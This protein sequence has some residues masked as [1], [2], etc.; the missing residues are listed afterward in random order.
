MYYGNRKLWAARKRMRELIDASGWRRMDSYHPATNKISM[1]AKYHSPRV[2]T[3]ELE[4]SLKEF[5][6]GEAYWRTETDAMQLEHISWRCNKDNPNNKYP[7]DVVIA[8]EWVIEALLDGVRFEYEDDDDEEVTHVGYIKVIDWENIEKNTF[9]YVENWQGAMNDRFAWDFVLFVNGLPLGGIVLEPDAD[10]A[11]PCQT[12]YDLAM[13]Q[14][15]NDFQ[16]PVY[17]Q[18]LIVS[19]GKQFMVGNPF[20]VEE[21]RKIDSLEKSL[22][23]IDFLKN[24]VRL[25]YMDEEGED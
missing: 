23:P 5:N 20:V 7:I 2:N 10:D 14:L 22:N 8:Q 12:A 21:L 19:N 13:Y 24:G 18:S 6:T 4:D 3:W 15:D 1:M 11:P 9:T 16:F 17:V 25:D